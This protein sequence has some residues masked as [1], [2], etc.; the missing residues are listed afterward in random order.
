MKTKHIPNLIKSSLPALLCLAV[1]YPTLP[2]AS[3]P[4]QA[5]V[6]SVPLN[7][8]IPVEETVSIQFAGGEEEVSF[9]GAIH[10]LI[11]PSD[12]VLPADPMGFQVNLAALQGVGAT[13]GIRYVVN[14]ATKTTV[15]PLSD[16]VSVDF[17]FFPVDP[18]RIELAFVWTE[19]GTLA[20]ITIRGIT[21][22]D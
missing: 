7:F 16:S 4:S 9:E 21:V 2:Q 8:F 12:P 17:Q 6:A 11:H 14:G 22:G 1:V 20:D 15:L 19:T 10:I 5:P 18:M 3:A 13:S